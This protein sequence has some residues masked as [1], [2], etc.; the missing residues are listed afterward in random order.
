MAEDLGNKV[1]TRRK[2]GKPHRF[3][4]GVSGNPNGRPKGSDELK[5][6]ARTFTPEA[7]AK[8]AEWMRSDNP[9]ASVGACGILLDRAW[10]K[11][12]QSFD[13]DAK[14]SFSDAFEQ[15]LNSIARR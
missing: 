4:K 5:D 2:P 12:P 11:A 15:F 8:L 6:L 9:K 14:V 7:I 3:Q 10:G 13:V 1:D